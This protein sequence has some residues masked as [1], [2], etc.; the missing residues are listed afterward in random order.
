[1]GTDLVIEGVGNRGKEDRVT[2]GEGVGNRGKENRV[3]GGQELGDGY[4]TFIK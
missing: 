4:T 2:G 1:M 3:T